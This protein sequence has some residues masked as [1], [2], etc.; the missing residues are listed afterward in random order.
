[1]LSGF[2]ARL[3]AKVGPEPMV[4]ANDTYKDNTVGVRMDSEVEAASCLL[5]A[6]TTTSI[7]TLSP[8]MNDE[9][10]LSANAI[11][12]SP[13]ATQQQSID[14]IPSLVTSVLNE[15]LEANK[16]NS[17]NGNITAEHSTSRKLP[18]PPTY[19]PTLAWVCTQEEGTQKALQST[20]PSN[21]ILPDRQWQS[22]EVHFNS[23]IEPSATTVGRTAATTIGDKNHPVVSLIHPEPPSELPKHVHREHDTS[24]CDDEESLESRSSLNS[25]N[26]S[27]TGT[28]PTGEINIYKLV[29]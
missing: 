3:S 24:D 6:E 20:M 23:N 5:K 27:Q 9:Y 13:P 11:L 4:N 21:N 18:G 25:V 7:T 28:K 16:S 17:L 29:G 2:D 14:V 22:R 1:M 19:M 10:S 26:S 8:T 15:R 12:T